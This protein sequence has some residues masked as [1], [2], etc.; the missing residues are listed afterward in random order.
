MRLAFFALLLLSSCA[1]VL[2]NSNTCGLRLGGDYDNRFGKSTLTLEQ[3][4]RD[5]DKALDATTFTTDFGLLSQT[6]NC[7]AMSGYVVYTKPEPSFVSWGRNVAGTT[8][9]FT[10]IIVIA[11]P[12]FGVW[13]RSALVHELFHVMQHCEARKPIDDGADAD[14]ANWLR[15]NIYHVI[16]EAEETP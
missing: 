13:R 5:V 14:H 11:T 3:L 6:D 15:D 7:A 4:Q 16:D 2:P 9:C 10:K 12:E 1:G 8:D